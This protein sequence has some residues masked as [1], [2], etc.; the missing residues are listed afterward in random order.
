MS[1]L[2]MRQEARR[3]GKVIRELISNGYNVRVE[4][5]EK[6]IQE[7]ELPAGDIYKLK[8]FLMDQFSVVLYLIFLSISIF[9]ILF[10]D[11]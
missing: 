2:I 4:I 9:I 3:R 5:H 11:E 6:S 7:P 1:S 8:H 10:N